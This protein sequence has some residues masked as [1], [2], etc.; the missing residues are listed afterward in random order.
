MLSNLIELTGLACLVGAAFLVSV[1]AGLL[2]LGVVL[3]IVGFA[4][5]GVKIRLPQR[6][7][8]PITDRPTPG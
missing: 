5:D 3:V 4:L 7:T 6:S 8:K 2:V 1:L